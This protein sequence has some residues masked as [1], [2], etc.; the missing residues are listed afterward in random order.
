MARC[1]AINVGANTNQPGFRGPIY[2]DGTFE[3]VPI[4][5]TEPTE[6]PVPTYGD[7]SLDL[8]I[9]PALQDTPVHL[10]PE[11]VDYPHCERYTYGDPYGV[12]AK[13]LLDLSVGDHVCFYA[14]LTYH[15]SSSPPAWI[16][17]DWGAYVFGR[18][19]LADDPIPG[20]QFDSLA[21]SQQAPYAG[22]AHLQRA[23]FDAAVLLRGDPASSRLYETGIPLSGPTGSTPNPLVTIH[24]MDSGRGPWWRR[25]LRFD[26]AGTQRLLDLENA[27]PSEK[28]AIVSA[29]VADQPSEG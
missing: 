26:N 22:N 19:T 10:D 3:F 11:F 18:F 23:T 2:P 15:G 8:D 29:A 12:K 27:A 28:R 17:D 21:P 4:P 24:S 5:E 25:P 16:A 14:T 13:P 20:D 6:T 1:V 7:L 9:P